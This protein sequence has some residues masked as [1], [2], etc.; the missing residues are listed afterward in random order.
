MKKLLY[1]V[2]LV[3]LFCFTIACKDKAAM[4]ELEKLRA[5]AAVEAQNID[6]VKRL[7][8]EFGK[9]NPGIIQDLYAPDSA[10]YSPSNN[11]TAL[12]REQEVD[13]VKMVLKAFPNMTYDIKDIFAV[14][15]RVVARIITSASH[16]SD[17]MG[18][19][20]TGKRAAI[21]ALIIFRIKDGKVIEEIEE[22]DFLGLFQQLGFELKPIEAK[23]K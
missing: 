6:L 1:V 2:P 3:I 8:A 7:F 4:T 22:A 9:G 5:Q 10:F 14:K 17:F 23:K 21:G 18:I 20:A 15:D 11:P 16:Q 19:S 13:Q 12:T